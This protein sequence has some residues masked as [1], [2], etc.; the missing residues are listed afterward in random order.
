MF[1]RFAIAAIVMISFAVPAGAADQGTINQTSAYEQTMMFYL[2]P[3]HG[4]P[5][6]QPRAQSTT[7]KALTSGKHAGKRVAKPT[8]VAINAVR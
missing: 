5:A 1:N 3:A 8:L 2:H 7:A 6:E 4:F